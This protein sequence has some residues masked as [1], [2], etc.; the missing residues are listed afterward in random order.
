[1]IV[2]AETGAQGTALAVSG[3]RGSVALIRSQPFRETESFLAAIRTGGG[4][5]VNRPWTAHS[6]HYP[7]ICDCS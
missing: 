2:A 5:G 7:W 4:E 1:M 3:S 6:F